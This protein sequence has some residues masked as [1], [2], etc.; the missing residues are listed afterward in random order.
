MIA[1]ESPESQPDAPQQRALAV[2]RPLA[3]TTDYLILVGLAVGS[4][5]LIVLLAS[6]RGALT[7]VLPAV[8]L[9]L[10]T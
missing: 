4:A 1:P 5:L 3:L 9:A 2:A 8:L 6:R 10:A 7:G